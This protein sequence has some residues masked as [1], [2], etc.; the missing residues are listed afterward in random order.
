MFF[1]SGNPSNLEGSGIPLADSEVLQYHREQ[2]ISEIPVSHLEESST[3]NNSELVGPTADPEKS[4]DEISLSS[5][6]FVSETRPE[7]SVIVSNKENATCQL[8]PAD[9]PL[10]TPKKKKTRPYI[11]RKIARN[12]G[13]GYT[14][15]K[16]KYICAKQFKHQLCNCKFDCKTVST[17]ERKKIFDKFWTSKSWQSQQNFIST[18]ILVSAAK[19]HYVQHSRRQNSRTFLLNKKRGCKR[20]FL[21]TLAI[22]NQRLHYCISKKASQNMCSP[23]RRG[24]VTPN[25]TSEKKCLEVR[26][27]LDSIPKYRSHYTQNEKLYFKEDLTRTMLYEE[28]KKKQ[29][30]KASTAVSKPIFYRLFKQYNIGIYVPKTDTP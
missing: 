20:V 3:E 10:L 6:S 25:R 21:T 24:K 27:F 16:G 19:R 4:F 23:D 9:R 14:T 7:S 5:L 13:Q 22:T 11:K 18:S 1:F 29:D 8:G 2:G 17:D 28:Y 30:A 12:S 15:E 26:A